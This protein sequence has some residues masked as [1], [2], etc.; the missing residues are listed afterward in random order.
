VPTTPPPSP[1]GHLRQ[2]R[3]TSHHGDY[4][5]LRTGRGPALITERDPTAGQG[6]LAQLSTTCQEQALATY[7]GKRIQDYTSAGINP[8]REPRWQKVLNANDLGTLK[9]HMP[10]LQ[11]HGKADEVIPWRVEAAS[12]RQW[13]AK[14]VT[15]LFTSCPVTTSQLRSRPSPRW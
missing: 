4:G 10:V 3:R 6:A 7:A 11:Y 2:A 15:T 13:C 9:P 12:H 1:L 14:G 8:I 5:Y